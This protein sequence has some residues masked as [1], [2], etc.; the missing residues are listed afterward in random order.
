MEWTGRS[1]SLTLLQARPITTA[2]PDTDEKRNWYLTLRPGDARLQ[3]LRKRVVDRLIPELEAEGETFAAEK[4]DPFDDRQLADA[5]E[6][7]NAAV[8]KWKQIY[9]DEFIPFAHGVRRLAIYYND[10]VQPEDPFEFVGLLRGQPLLAAQRNRA[11]GELAQ[12]LASNHALRNAAEEVLEKNAGALQWPAAR[13]QLMRAA[14][15]AENFVRGFENLIERFLDIT[16][17]HERLHD[18]AESLLRNL[19]ELSRRPGSFEEESSISADVASLEQRIFDAV[20]PE[21]HAEAVEIIETGRVSWKLRDDDNLLV[22]RLESQL[23]RAIE[24]AASRLRKRGA[25]VGV[26]QPRR[27]HVGLL[28][29]ALRAE[30][31]DPIAFEISDQP[32]DAEPSP[33]STGETPRQLIGQPA[34]PGVG[35]GLVRCIRGRDDLSRFRGGEVLVC[36]AIQP[37]MTHLVPLAS[38]IV[39]RRGG[40]LI[41]GAII[42][43]E[44][45][46]PCVNGVRD[47]VELLE[48]GDFVTVDGHLG[49]VAVGAPEF[50]LEL[51]PE[52]ARSD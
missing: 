4:L 30:S 17:G 20:D 7:R 2:A 43:R 18:E 46:I 32:L 24:V 26:A 15:G 48:N 12:R 42:A 29:R 21:R 5:L 31:T 38:A 33:R 36:D 10:A 13:E 52:S 40:M 34:S 22:S 11:I 27:E 14:V 49:I 8:A 47:A 23:L 41:H 51:S 25:L 16:Y 19:I 37:T 3:Q 50:D 28:A 45:G 6:K 39:E 44:L 35:T 9:W 1:A